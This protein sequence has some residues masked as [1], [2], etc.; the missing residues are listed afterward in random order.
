MKNLFYCSDC[1][2]VLP[3]I[4]VHAEYDNLYQPIYYCR[5]CAGT[6][7]QGRKI[8]KALFREFAEYLVQSGQEEK[9]Y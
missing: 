2:K 4:R 7:M 3:R 8:S 6:V 1:E 9:Y 5:R